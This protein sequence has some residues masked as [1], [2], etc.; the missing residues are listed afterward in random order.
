MNQFL[1]EFQDFLIEK[2]LLPSQTIFAG[3][4][5]FHVDDVNN[6]FSNKFLGMIESF[7]LYQQV[8]EITHEK[9]H[10]LDLVLANNDSQTFKISNIRVEQCGISDHHI[11]L[12]D[13]NVDK[14]RPLHKTINY[15]QTKNI[16]IP[17]FINDIK[18]SGLRN[19]VSKSA[20]VSDKVDSF[21]RNMKNI[22]DIHAPFKTKNIVCRPNTRW[23]NREIS[24]AKKAQREA[25]RTWRISK[26][27]VHR[28]ITP[29]INSTFTPGGAF[30]PKLNCDKY[31]SPKLNY[32]NI[33][34]D[35]VVYGAS[36]MCHS[37]LYVVFSYIL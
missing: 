5:N 10:T 11:V 25:E 35:C 28:Q 15:R 26:L 33:K 12:F 18:N 9:R 29:H 30:S 14:P 7:N 2:T 13:L 32:D 37:F 27:E 8:R 3:D 21:N 31:T 22:L 23:F 1:S 34:D 16:D 6:N 4:F 20:T 17:A 24:E 36:S 19:E